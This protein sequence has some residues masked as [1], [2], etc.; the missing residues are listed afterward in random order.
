MKITHYFVYFCD[1]LVN[2]IYENMIIT[3]DAR[4]LN[5]LDNSENKGICGA[6]L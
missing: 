4:P 6:I 1:S 3:C 2:F 5:H